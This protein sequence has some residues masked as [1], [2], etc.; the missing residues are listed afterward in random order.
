MTEVNQ[1]NL[2]NFNYYEWDK[3]LTDVTL[4]EYLWIDGSGKKV[5]SKTMVI[6]EKVTSLE[7]L[8]WWT[9]DGSSC[10]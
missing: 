8:G 3:T 2:S 1:R 4:A 10:E 5:R 7:Q 6:R 9:Y